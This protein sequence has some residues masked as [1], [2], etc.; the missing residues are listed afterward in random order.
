MTIIASENWK[1]GEK[2][3]KRSHKRKEKNITSRGRKIEKSDRVTAKKLSL[4]KQ[5]L[6]SSKK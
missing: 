3:K 5:K 6:K 2:K 1:N 4:L